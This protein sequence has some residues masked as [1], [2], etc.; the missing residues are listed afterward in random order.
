VLAEFWQIPTL[1]VLS[2]S[3]TNLPQGSTEQQI[4]MS[5]STPPNH[6]YH[7]HCEHKCLPTI[8]WN[9]GNLANGDFVLSTLLANLN[10]LPTKIFP[11]RRT[12]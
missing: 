6:Y 7:N 5:T 1:A 2:Q 10:F 3:N 12:P 11:V 9:E 8:N 4:S